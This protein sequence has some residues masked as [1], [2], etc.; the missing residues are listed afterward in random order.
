MTPA[1]GAAP[2]QPMPRAAA[3]QL[4]QRSRESDKG[5]ATMVECRYSIVNAGMTADAAIRA[6]RRCESREKVSQVV[7]IA[8]LSV[9]EFSIPG[10]LTDISTSGAGLELD[11]P[12][13]AGAFLAVEW[14]DTLVLAE[15][16]YC[17]SGGLQYRAGL[18]INYIILDRTVERTR[19]SFDTSGAACFLRT[20]GAAFKVH[21]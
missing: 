6:D 18:R 1:L 16:L 8:E 21:R 9:M 2:E 11:W 4:Q 15:V 5:K 12:I 13:P 3:H 7:T 20:L 19:L 10:A 17:T 14:D